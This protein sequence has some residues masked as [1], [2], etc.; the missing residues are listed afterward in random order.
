MER[1]QR[2]IALTESVDWVVVIH[3][4]EL[5]FK[6]VVALAVQEVRQ[7]Q[8]LGEPLLMEAC[9]PDCLVVLDSLEQVQTQ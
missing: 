2:K 9:S 6:F 5:L 4:L 1:D 8:P 7:D 3:L